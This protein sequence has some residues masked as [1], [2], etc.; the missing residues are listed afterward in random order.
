MDKLGN[1]FQ[2]IA[3]LDGS[4]LLGKLGQT[5]LRRAGITA[6]AAAAAAFLGQADGAEEAADDIIAR[7]RFVIQALKRAVHGEWSQRQFTFG[8]LGNQ[9]RPA[10]S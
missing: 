3:F 9:I 6:V 4:T 10:R 1:D 2:P 7:G 5:L 8:N